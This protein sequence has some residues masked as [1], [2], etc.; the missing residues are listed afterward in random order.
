MNRNSSVVSMDRPISKQRTGSL[1]RK[2]SLA[3]LLFVSPMIIGVTFLT[4]IPIIATFLISFSD[5]NFIMGLQGFKWVGLSNFQTLISDTAFLK[6]MKNNAMFLLTVPIYMGISLVLAILI[7]KHIYFKSFFKVAFF[8][9][10]ISSV[11]A[12]ATVWMVLFNPS[13]GPVN[14]F[15]TSIGID[16]PP[17]WIADPSYALP[18]LMMVSIWIS[19]GFNMIIYIA[20]LQNIPKDLYEAADI[21]GAN[22][23]VKF[24]K[25]TLPLLSPTTFFLLVS[26][27]IATF[28]VFDLIAILTRGGPMRSTSM[29]VWDMYEMAFVNL[30][31]GYAS[32]MASVLFFCVLLIT[33]LQWLGQK[34]WVN[35]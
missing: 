12:V 3:G 20:G 17:K 14:Q 5:W 26:G 31:I 28:K 13:T 6:S 19:I 35:Y 34:K 2:E 1:Q 8:M 4:L 29:M 33:I 10:Y 27:I 15:L 30:K 21:D 18:S 23:W 22:G 7:E 32:S 16:N 11:V 24:Q 25:I 9:P